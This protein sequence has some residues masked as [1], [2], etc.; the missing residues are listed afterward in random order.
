MNSQGNTFT[1]C[2]FQDF[3]CPGCL[4]CPILDHPNPTISKFTLELFE[5]VLNDPWET[6][7]CC[8]GRPLS[9]ASLKTS[10]NV[11]CNKFDIALCQV[12]RFCDKCQF[13]SFC[14][15]ASQCSSLCKD[16]KGPELQC[17][18]SHCQSGLGKCYHCSTGTNS[19]CGLDCQWEALRI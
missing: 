17:A 16:C 9:L 10:L 11:C 1:L 2:L 18:S 8:L 6:C 12:N 15:D 14:L 19:Y 13:K 5:R 4:D 3:V 7:W